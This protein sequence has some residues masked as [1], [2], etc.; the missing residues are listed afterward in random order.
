[1]RGVAVE[2][3]LKEGWRRNPQT[4]QQESFL[5]IQTLYKV[6]SGSLKEKP[7]VQDPVSDPGVY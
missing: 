6:I 4:G 7:T 1:M 2:F 3:V 5:D